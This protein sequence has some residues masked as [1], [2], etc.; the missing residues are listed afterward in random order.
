MPQPDLDLPLSGMRVIDLTTTLAGP[1]STQILGDFGADVI[2]IEA[3]GGDGIRHAGP[4]RNERMSAVF[5]NLNRNKRSVELDLKSEKARET[6][7]RLID[8]ADVFLHSIRPQKIVKLGFAAPEVM[9]RN[10]RLVYAALHGYFQDGPYGG[11][12]AYDDVIQGEAG[13]ASTFQLRDGEPAFVPSSFVDKNTGMNMAMGVLAALLQ[14]ERTGRGAFL[15]V[16]MFEGMVGYNL[17]EHLYGRTFVPAKGPAGYSRAIS[18]YR[19]PHRTKD[20]Y[21]CML[22][23]TDSQWRRFWHLAGRPELADDQRFEKMNARSKNSD[24]LYELA[25]NLLREKESDEWLKLLRQ[26]EIPVGQVNDIDE[27]FNDFHL[28][29]IGFFRHYEHPT[30]GEL[31]APE[32]AFRINHQSLPLRRHPPALGEHNNEIL[33]EIGC[34]AAEIEELRIIQSG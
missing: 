27:L 25:G 23:Y 31:L 26:A 30:E 28:Q 8:T 34:S 5:L 29:Q 6:L 4:A 14:R 16:G 11:R 9:A 2:K 12:P 33:A 15:E 17:I 22:P 21:I 32:T 20:S 24:E 18:K 13:I 7:W 10:N 1:L 19:R 3:P